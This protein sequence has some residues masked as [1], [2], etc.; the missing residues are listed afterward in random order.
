MKFYHD[1]RMGMRIVEVD[2]LSFLKDRNHSWGWLRRHF[3][4]F[5]LKL[6][7][8]R[9]DRIYV[10]DCLVAVDLVRYYFIPKE[11]IVV[12]LEKFPSFGNT[13]E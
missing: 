12:D 13:Q 5:R 7:L 11:K 1:G 10:P 9:A 3:N 6:A 2:D 8:R 4:H